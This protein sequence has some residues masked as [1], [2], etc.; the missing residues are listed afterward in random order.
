[1]SRP[2][3]TVIK[4]GN[5]SYVT[6]GT[7][8]P[9]SRLIGFLDDSLRSRPVPSNGWWQGLLMHN[10]GY[11]MYMNPLTAT[12]EDNG[13]WLT[14]PGAGFYD[15]FVPG[16]G[17]QTIDIDVHDIHIGYDELDEE[18]S[19][20]RVTG[21]SD[22]GVSAVLTDDSN[23]DKLTV[24][25]SQGSLYSFMFFA[26]PEKAVIKADTLVA[27][28][29][30]EG[31]E[32]LKNDESNYRGDS[33]V[34]VVKT[35]SGYVDG[36]RKNYHTDSSGNKVIVEN[37]PIYEERY[38]VVSVPEETEFTFI[39]DVIHAKMLKGNYMSV[40][41]VSQKNEVNKDGI[42]LS[43]K[44]PFPKEEI[45]QIHQ[46][47]YSFVVD[48]NCLYSFNNVTNNVT[49]EFHMKTFLVRQN[50]SSEAYTA[51]LPHHLAHSTY[52]GGY[53]YKSVRG[54]CRSYVG[55]TFVTEDQFHGIVPTYCEPTDDGYDTNSLYDLLRIVYKNNGGEKAPEESNLISGDPYWQGKNLH[56]LSMA[57]L[58]ADQVGATNLRDEMLDK[59]EY[60]LTDWFTYNE[61]KDEDKSSYFY[62]DQEWG[63]G[64]VYG[65]SNFYGTFFNGEPLYVYGIHL[66]PGQEYLTSLGLNQDE[67]TKLKTAIDKLKH[68]QSIWELPESDRNLHAWQHIFISII[69]IYDHDEAIN[70]YK[71]C[72]ETMGNIGNDQ[73]QYNVYW[74]MYGL[75]SVGY[76]TTDIWTENGQPATMYV[77]DNVYKAICWNPTQ[78]EQKFIFKNNEKVVGS[79]LIPPKTLLTV[80]PFKETDKPLNYIVDSEFS[81]EDSF[82]TENAQIS[83]GKI[84]FNE[85]GHSSY[86]LTFGEKE[87]YRTAIINFTSQGENEGEIHFLIDDKEIEISKKN[88]YYESLPFSITFKHTITLRGTKI[89]V[90][91]FKFVKQTLVKSTVK[92]TATAS[93]SN[94]NEN[95]PEKAVDGDSETRWESS[96][97]ID[98]VQL[99]LSLEE[100]TVIYQL[101]VHW[102][103]ASAKEY[104]VLF[105]DDGKEWNEVAHVNSNQGQRTDFVTPSIHR[106]VSFIRIDCISR[107]TNYGYSIYEVEIYNF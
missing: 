55:N 86:H 77:K 56:P 44:L 71:D 12:F 68:E 3:K 82:E 16:T 102:E 43:T 17:S 5:G 90:D 75:K 9:T 4:H 67:R 14:N 85:D 39:E 2:E 73:E 1:M 79:A 35:H 101:Q 25:L 104:R 78:D 76:R 31:N 81:I 87:I 24:F 93:S 53:T 89:T 64:Q 60:I 7:E 36:V 11:N 15:G 59:I 88:G 23:V 61:T 107:N 51:F 48:T 49:T 84:V 30:I 19:E 58:V 95:T 69:S 28:Y 10:K 8:F 34:V 65:A 27:V 20:V 57:T 52:K 6:G 26:E 96:H 74:I 21:Y 50:Y 103:A 38:Y 105:S 72:I 106:K 98:S 41:A 100:P 97:N 45:N 66:I 47:G 62:Y 54:D 33:I 99:D 94:G 42:S 63:T 70:W 32:I 92:M 40:G 83:D 18:N 13:L 22:F 91:A 80:D 29:D 46:H 37:D